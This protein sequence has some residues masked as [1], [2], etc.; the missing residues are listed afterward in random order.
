MVHQV[1][2]QADHQQVEAEAREVVQVELE[3]EGMQQTQVEHTEQVEAPAIL[4]QIME[5]VILVGAMD[6]TGVLEETA[7]LEKT[8]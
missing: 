1:Q 2:M 7:M 3:L 4:A 5:P 6:T 8:V